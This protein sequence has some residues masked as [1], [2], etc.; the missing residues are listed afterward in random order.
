MTQGIAG[1][2]VT[3]LFDFFD[4]DSGLPADP[5]S[6]TLDITYG[7]GVGF[8]PDTAGPFT[9]QGSSISIPGEV[10]RIGLGQYAFSWSIPY[11]A[12]TGVYVANW[13]WQYNGDSDIADENFPVLGGAFPNPAVADVG[14]W[15]GG[16]DYTPDP[17]NL[18]V[19]TGSSVPFGAVDGNGIAWMVNKV[20]GWDGCDIQG[21]GVI[22]KTGDHGGWPT[23]QFYAPRNLTITLT[24]IAP[25]QALR[26]LARSILQKAVPVSDLALFT[27]NEPVPKQALIRR[28]GKLAEQYY[29]LQ[30]VTFTIGAVA[31][32]PR[33]YA[34]AGKILGPVAVQ[35]PSAI[36]FTSPFT[37]P[38]TQPA[39]LT[40]GAVAA[41]NA[42]DF[43][44][45]PVITI[46]GPITAPSLT[47]VNT[48]QVVSWSALVLGAGDQLVVDFGLRQAFLDGAFR[49]A[50]PLSSW[51][52]LPDGTTTIQLGGSADAG[53]SY[54]VVYADAFQ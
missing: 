54:Q 46:N 18:A 19:Y 52:V 37:T 8:V 29:D 50:D 2:P 42:G 7:S 10:Y 32:D 49:S 41:F 17:S 39:Q 4:E 5:S 28:S 16:I 9:Y 36:G 20:E 27:L 48:G 47:N 33:K 1:Q 45:R 35:S 23:P 22:P 3:L 31:P 34:A 30:S 40:G 14:F 38:L 43:E 53:A 21:A 25:T 44:T 26:D 13:T 12:S 6:I 51:W 15:T 24:A 11:N